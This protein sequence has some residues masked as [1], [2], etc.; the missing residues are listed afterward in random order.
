M[1]N[2]NAYK[3][4]VEVEFTGAET[5]TVATELQIILAGTGIDVH[6]EGYNHQTRNHWKVTTDA[7]V[8]EC[9]DYRNGSGFGGELVSPVL[10]GEAGL[11]EMKKVLD[12]LNQVANG[13][14]DVDRRCGVHV[15]LSLIQG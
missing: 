4:G 11:A 6:L 2:L 7:T 5:Q 1:I 3:F 10:H 12:A 9:R 8:T 15:H 13:A 14:V